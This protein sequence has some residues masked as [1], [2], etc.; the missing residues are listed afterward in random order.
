[1][2]KISTVA[3]CGV[4]PRIGT[5]TQALQIVGYLKMMGYSA[6]Y[7]ELNGHAYIDNM[8][9]LY[10][11]ISISGGCVSYGQLEMYRSVV[12]VKSEEDYDFLVKDYGSMDDATFNKVSFLEQDVQVICGGVKPNEIFKVN[13]ILR[14]PEYHPARFIFSFAPHDQKDGILQL[15]T[16]RADKTFFANYNAD[17]FVYDSTM[18]KPYRQ[19]LGKY[20]DGM[21][22]TGSRKGKHNALQSKMVRQFIGQ[23]KNV[24]SN[25]TVRTILLALYTVA[26]AFIAIKL[27]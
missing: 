20:M 24:Q 26:V 10:R 16:N 22:P 4:Q 17:P 11:D 2:K 14:L 6:A 8:R 5:T 25:R 27:F 19:I 7:I 21:M 3:V 13:D 1:M 23:L 9:K 12:D 15:M 18:N